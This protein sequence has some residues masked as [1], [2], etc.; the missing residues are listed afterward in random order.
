MGGGPSP[1]Q[2]A[3]A[4]SQANLNAQLGSAFGKQEAFT[5]AQQNKVNPFY[6]QLM[7]NGLPYYANVADQLSGTTAQ[8]FIPAKA[9]LERAIGQSANALPSGFAQQARTDLASDQARAYDQSL[10][11]LLGANFQAKQQGA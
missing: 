8:A 4:Q 11:G 3:A 7:Q 2:K 5:E 1:E 6:T 9:Q 10:Q